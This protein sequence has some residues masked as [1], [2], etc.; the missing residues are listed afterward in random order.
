[1]YVYAVIFTVEIYRDFT[2]QKLGQGVLVFIYKEKLK[3]AQMDHSGNTIN[4]W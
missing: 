4:I 2:W 3:R 1:M